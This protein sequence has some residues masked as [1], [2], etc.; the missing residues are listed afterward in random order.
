MSSILEKKI[1]VGNSSGFF[2]VQKFVAF[3]SKYYSNICL[4]LFEKRE[5]IVLYKIYISA[6]DMMFFLSESNAKI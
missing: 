6:V 3:P 4:I 1:C 5:N 2:L